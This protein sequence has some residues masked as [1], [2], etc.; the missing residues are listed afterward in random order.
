MAG[1]IAWFLLLRTIGRN[2][3]EESSVLPNGPEIMSVMDSLLKEPR[4]SF[5]YPLF[6]LAEIALKT[7]LA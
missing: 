2:I 6:E 5:L 7:A 3:L 1:S 4:V